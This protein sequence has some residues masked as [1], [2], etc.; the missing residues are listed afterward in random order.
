MPLWTALSVPPAA[1]SVGC[2]PQRGIK[3]LWGV[4]MLS[5]PVKTLDNNCS[6]SHP[7]S[8]CWELALPNVHA[9]Q[10]PD[11]SFLSLKCYLMM[12]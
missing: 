3:V 12:T 10:F 4:C 2:L 6:H 9:K 1:H 8:S 11:F 7:I 5:F